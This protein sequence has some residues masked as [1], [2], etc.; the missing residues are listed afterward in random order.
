[1][2]LIL[3]YRYTYAYIDYLWMILNSF[4]LFSVTHILNNL[5]DSF[6]S[7]K[8]KNIIINDFE[9]FKCKI[10]PVLWKDVIKHFYF[11]YFLFVNMCL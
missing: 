4:K 5:C 9:L 1:M 2:I 10:F 8:F 11:K 6:L 7:Q 3:I